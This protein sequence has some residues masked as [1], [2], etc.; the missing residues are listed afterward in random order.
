MTIDDV[1]VAVERGELLLSELVGAIA[2]LM[3]RRNAAVDAAVR[4][5]EL[6]ADIA[7]EAKLKGGG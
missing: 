3:K 1:I 2:D 6:A 5:I 4:G 7:E